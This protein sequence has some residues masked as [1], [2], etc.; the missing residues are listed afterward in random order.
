MTHDPSSSLP[1]DGQI[2]PSAETKL[3]KSAERTILIMEMLGTARDP[4]T[5][6]ELRRRTGYP[7]SSLHQLLHTLI[8]MRWIEP[9]PDG[10]AV[11]VG[12]HALLCGT[13]YLDRDRALPYATRTLELIGEA[14]G[15]TTHYARLDG[16]NVIYLATRET[17]E[18]R[19]A[20]S[21]VG[22]QLP[23]HAT[24]L[25]KA[26]LA[27]RAADELA[28]LLPGAPLAR[29]TEHTITGYDGLMADLEE[30]RA[31]GYSL[32]REE[33][34]PS[35]GCVAVTVAYRIPATDAISCSLPIGAATDEETER[36]ARI[37]REHAE[38]L[39]ARL[40]AEGIR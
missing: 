17:I 22:R 14:T 25:G 40:R 32:E 4:V 9:T 28:Q 19:R 1:M 34:T 7:R 39:A 23:A 18:P 2:D 15:Y 35:I 16:A 8:A 12:P 13:A 3:V 10:S 33:N 37:M 20:T 31:R 5:V 27:E 30:T 21:R 36:V 29:L 6:A 11:G 26:L 38:E 24:A